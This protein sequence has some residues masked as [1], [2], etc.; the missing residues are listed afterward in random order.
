MLCKNRYFTRF[1]RM[2]GRG[3]EFAWECGIISPFMEQKTKIRIVLNFLA[4]V[5]LIVLTAEYDHSR[6][7]WI[8]TLEQE[9]YDQ[10]LRG[11]DALRRHDIVIV[12]IDRDTLR[13]FGAWPL[14]RD[15]F[16][17]LNEQLFGHYR[18]LIAAY[19]LPFSYPDDG[20]MRLLR[21]LGERL[22]ADEDGNFQAL[23]A[24][25]RLRDEY[26]YDRHMNETLLE[27]PVVLGYAFD[28]TGRVEGALPPP[29][30]RLARPDG[31]PMGKLA[32]RLLTEEWESYSGY[33]GNLPSYLQAVE[34]AAGHVNFLPDE[35]GVVRRAPYFIRHAG[36]VYPSLPLA[37]YMR[38][39]NIGGED[40]VAYPD[41]DGGLASI[42]VGLRRAPMNS[43]GSLYLNYMGRGGRNVNFET[44][45]G[46]V[47]RYV[48]FADVVERKVPLEHLDDKIVFV[49]SSSAQLR[50]L[51]ATPVNP[52]MP[53]VEV[54]ATQLANLMGDNI[55]QRADGTAFREI[56]LALALAL[57][58]SVLFAVASPLLAGLGLAAALAGYAYFVAVQWDNHAIWALLPICLMMLGVFLVNTVVGF[59]MTWQANRHLQNTFGQYVPPEFAKKIGASD[60]AINMEGEVR[61]LSVLFSDVRDFTAISETLS[62]RELTLLMNRM[63]TDLTEVIHRHGGTV[64]K[65]IGDAI[66]AFWNAPLADDAHARRSVLA[67]LDM[68]SAMRNLSQELK[69]QGF[70]RELRLGVGICTGDAN[71]GNMG[72]N[73]RMAYTAIGD[74]VNLASR[75]EGLTK[76]YRCS[77]LITESTYAQCKDEIACR[78]VDLVRVKGRRQPAVLYEP[79]GEAHRLQPE[80]MAAVAEFERF[81]GL[82]AAGE[83]GAAG[84][85]LRDY[86]TRNPEDGLIAV[87]EERIAQLQANPPA[88]WDGILTH[89]SK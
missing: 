38:L 71:V 87:Y 26:D 13:K 11:A 46:A 20:A 80:Q 9:N 8:H 59:V 3:E 79:M 60:K 57:A 74:T 23:L 14:S 54:L 1:A 36:G 68:Q 43:H 61:E 28:A 22:R 89:E 40:I 64:D 67:A 41:D 12:D 21:A 30:E 65:Y 72:S 33:L 42:G 70:E 78:P 48:S 75:T 82:Y 34:S 7:S 44:T 45:P 62:P 51:F 10:R 15:L 81:L 29:I 5:V 35:D 66:M 76:Y 77:V 63:L 24:V 17:R 31:R 58:L 85:A 86:R 52:E 32:M 39:N 53:G 4:A 83:F 19:A 25:N 16:A 55:L 50:L 84:E 27:T 88:H 69:R 6:L 56:M 49:G 47:F 37:V 73:L 18:V 2:R